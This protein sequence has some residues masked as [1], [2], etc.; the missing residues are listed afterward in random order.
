MSA[1]DPK[2]FSFRPIQI[3]GGEDLPFLAHLYASTRLEEMA[4]SGWESEQIDNFLKQQFEAQHVFYMEQFAD[5]KFDL[6]L[7]GKGEPI[8]RLYLEER[9]EEFRIIDIALLPEFRGQGTGSIILSQIIEQASDHGKVVRIHVEQNNPAMKLYLRVGFRKVE[10][11]G[12]Y[13]LMEHCDIGDL[14]N[15][16][17]DA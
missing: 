14:L 16:S 8:G 7:S 13:I 15:C 9:E 5:A 4:A 2:V 1:C 6:I 12:L 3:G 10:T 11:K 17:P